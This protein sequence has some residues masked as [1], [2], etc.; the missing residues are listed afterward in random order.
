M[1]NGDKCYEEKQSKLKGIES[2][3]GGRAV[4]IYKMTKEG[5]T[6]QLKVQEIRE[7]TIH[8]YGGREL[9]E[10]GKKP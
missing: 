5:L 4:N 9:Q 8:S 3:V 10:D 1:L 6:E 2:T 7:H